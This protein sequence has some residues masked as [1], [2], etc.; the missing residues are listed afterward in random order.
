MTKILHRI[1]WIGLTVIAA[2][3][4]F[5]VANDL[6]ADR[7]TGIPVDHAGAFH[8]LAG[9]SFDTVQQASPGVAQYITTIEVGYALHELT[10]VALFLA[11]VLIP[12]RRRQPWAWWACW[13]IMIA[14][15]GYTF[16]IARHDSTIMSRSLI[17]DIAVPILLLVC[18]PAVLMRR[19][20]TSTTA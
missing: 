20:R 13:A 17:A 11:L 9:Q 14:N 12:L 1:G 4:L 8:A 18:A 16:T 3:L 2:F 6:G 19:S 5:A 7:S 10:F 15:L